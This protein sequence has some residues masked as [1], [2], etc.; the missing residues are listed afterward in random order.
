MASLDVYIYI[1]IYIYIYMST[2]MYIWALEKRSIKKKLLLILPLINLHLSKDI[3][4]YLNKNLHLSTYIR[5]LK[6]VKYQEISFD[7]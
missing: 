1:Y 7:V 4:I 3:L 2:S 5:I 6:M